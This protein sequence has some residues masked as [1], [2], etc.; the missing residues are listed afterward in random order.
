MESHKGEFTI[1]PVS[2][3]LKQNKRTGDWGPMDFF[4]FG[5]M[6]WKLP[7]Q[8]YDEYQG[9]IYRPTDH[10]RKTDILNTEQEKPVFFFSNYTIQYVK[11]MLLGNAWILSLNKGLKMRFP[12]SSHAL[13]SSVGNGG[14]ALVRYASRLF[15]SHWNLGWHL[16]YLGPEGVPAWAFQ[17]HCSWSLGILNPQN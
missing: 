6:E 9:D 13:Q 17:G 4:W 1:T 8:Y 15:T 11:D 3:E 12:V 10:V 5:P 16:T 2:V 14:P 7:I